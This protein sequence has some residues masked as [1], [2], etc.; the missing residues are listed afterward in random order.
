MSTIAK[1]VSVVVA[2]TLVGC[3]PSTRTVS[4]AKPAAGTSEQKPGDRLEW[5]RDA[6]FGMFIHWGLYAIPAG[7]W[8]GEAGYGEWIRDNAHIPIEQYDQFVRQFNPVKFNA[9]Q[10]VRIAKAAGAKYIVI[11]TKHHDGFCLFDSKY[12]DFDVMSTPFKRDIMKALADACHREGLR[13]CWY[14]SIMDWHHPDYLPRRGWEKRSAE[15]A[16]FNRYVACLKD[17]VKELLTNYGDIGVMWFDGEWEDTWNHHYGQDLY[18]FV[19]SVQPNVIVNN[20][21]DK[22]RGGMGG[23]SDAGFA[24][25]YGTPEQEIPPT[26]IPGVDWETCMTMNDH[27]GYNRL[28]Q[29]WKSSESLIRMLVD[30]ASKGGNFLLNVGPTPEGEIPPPSVERLAAIGKWLQV[31]GESI[32]GTSASPFKSLTWGRCTQRRLPNGDTRLYL[33]V[34]EWPKNGKL[35]IPGI[36]NEARRAY[37]L[38]DTQQ[39]ALPVSRLDDALA[40]QMTGPAPDPIATPVVLDVVGRPDIVDPPTISAPADIF[41]DVLDVTITANRDSVELR[42]TTD[43]TDPTTNSIP[44]RGRIHVTATAVLAARAFSNGRPVSPVSRRAFTKV[45]PRPVERVEG[46][47]GGLDYEYYEGTW[48]KLPDFT[49][50]RPAKTGVVNGFDLSPRTGDEHFAFRYRGFIRLPKDGVYTF[51]IASDDG[52]RLYVGDTL[53]VDNDLLHG[54]EEKS[55]QVALAGGL[56]SIAV[57]YFNCTGGRGLEV[58]YAGPGIDKQTISAGVLFRRATPKVDAKP[59]SPPQ[60]TPA[61][62]VQAPLDEP[63]ARPTPAQIAWHDSEIGMFIHFAPNTYTDQEYDDL[64]L[65]LERFNPVQL[66]TDQWVTAA[67][68][69][70]AKYIVFVAKHAGGFCMWPTE[71]TDYGIKNTPWRDGKG[72]VLRDLSESCRKRE[73]KLGVYVSPCDRKQGAEGGGRCKA[74]EAQEAYDTLYRRQLTEVLSGYGEML[75]IWFDGSVVVPVGDILRQYAPRAMIFQGPHATIRWVGNEDGFAPYPAWNALADKDAKSG[76]ATA[77]HG[78]PD[79]AAWLPL[80]CGARMRNTW[81]WNTRNAHTLKTVDQLMDMY[82]RSV[83]HGAVLLLNHTPDTTGRIPEADVKRGAEFAAEVQ[84]R[85]GQSIAETSGSGDVIELTLPSR[86][87]VDHV[88]TMEDISQG[89]RVREYVIE[90]L[91]DGKWQPLCQGTAIG[92]KKIDCF[93]SIETAKVRL[94]VTKAVGTPQ[95]RRL[96]L[97]IVGRACDRDEIAPGDQR[98]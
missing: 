30:I 94:R 15:G 9:E 35:V 40:V 89:E 43:G 58:S 88:I 48:E 7:E 6:R 55:G 92:R 26:G 33:H 46:V 98:L 23:M 64:S 44:I 34:F 1:S 97:Y 86:A 95:I 16:D 2:L 66:D 28:D 37:L 82:Y 3:A 72:D 47:V 41:V 24:G 75:E 84:R 51:Y 18:D 25:D 79:G 31:N 22:G 96:A 91:V 87:F 49:G 56:H 4:E 38:M 83:G 39:T 78:K 69:I 36:I 19:R 60:A 45:T 65:P 11:T 32:Y 62:A 42:Y 10:W 93:T 57:T 76:E 5:W 90:A 53:V 81:F 27:W 67:E 12:T 52:S 80:E 77:E 54:L 8:Q 63:Q 71:T 74:P 29:N 73:M 70:G 61:G 14:H 17:Q 59:E 20:R 50:S 13:M 68:A 21:V 85:F